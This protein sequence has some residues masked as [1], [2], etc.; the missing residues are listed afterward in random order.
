M[1]ELVFVGCYTGDAGNG[2]GITTFSRSPSGSLR[3]VASLPLESPSWLT[4]HPSLPVLYAVNETDTGGVTALT[5]DDSGVLSV[6]S[7]AETGG[8]HPCH[9]AVTPDGRFLLCANYTGGSLAVFSLSPSGA[10][11]AR[12]ALVQH[13]G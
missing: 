7:T 12:T 9:L 4:R 10:L 11:V 6:L 8:A 5:W 13:S 3:E 2:T 1:A